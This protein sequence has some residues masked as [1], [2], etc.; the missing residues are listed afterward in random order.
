MTIAGCFLAGPDLALVWCDT[1]TFSGGR[2]GKHRNKL[3]VNVA[4]GLA[5]TGA[6]WSG[7]SD[8]AAHVADRALNIDDAIPRL[9]A[10]LRE[11]A[12]KMCKD[13][14]LHPAEIGRATIC[15]AGWSHRMGR[16]VAYEAAGSALFQPVLITR[17]ASPWPEGWDDAFRP[18]D[19][20]SLA[21]LAR[22]QLG[23]LRESWPDAEAGILSLAVIRPGHVEAGPFLDFGTGRLLWPGLTGSV[24]LTEA[25][26]PASGPEDRVSQ[27]IAA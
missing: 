22:R 8:A 19:P 5:C 12:L 2:P 15:L 1:E 14:H 7:L 10:P 13:T 9:G 21:D 3:V 24:G 6:G 4:A 26:P 23:L 25:E 20:A 18:D 17:L 27:P 11:T 16:V